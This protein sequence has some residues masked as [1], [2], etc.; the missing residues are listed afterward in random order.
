MKRRAV[1][2]GLLCYSGPVIDWASGEA[3]IVEPS[4]TK[5]RRR[6]KPCKYAEPTV[7]VTLWWDRRVLAVVD[8]AASAEGV[9]RSAFVVAVVRAAIAKKEKDA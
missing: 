4:N 6:G 8:A 9:S 1:G 2:T 5:K 7:R 3:R